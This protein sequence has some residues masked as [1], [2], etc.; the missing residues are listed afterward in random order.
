MYAPEFYTKCPT[1][2]TLSSAA[3][4]TAGA[5]KASIALLP[6][7]LRSPI[8]PYLIR[9][10]YLLAYG[11][12]AIEN[13]MANGLW[14][15]RRKTLGR[16]RKTSS[17]VAESW[18]FW[19]LTEISIHNSRYHWSEKAKYWWIVRVLRTRKPPLEVAPTT[20]S[21]LKAWRGS[22]EES[23]VNLPTNYKHYNNT[24]LTPMTPT[25]R[26]MASVCGTRQLIAR[27]LLTAQVD[28]LGLRVVGHPELS[29]YIH[30]MNRM[31]SRTNF[32]HDST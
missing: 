31:N 15:E 14:S 26:F 24:V 6:Q 2:H 8:S 12:E 10:A 29:L 19:R 3:T 22:W 20:L 21:V 23:Y 17:L 28:W 4:F 5:A 16:N 1:V 30:Q 25:D 9:R 18:N 32:G 11:L 27:I 7:M 13:C